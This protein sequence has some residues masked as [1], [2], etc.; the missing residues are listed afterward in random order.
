MRLLVFV[1][2]AFCAWVSPL[3]A[4]AVDAPAKTAPD[5]GAYTLFDPVPDTALRDFATDRPTKSNVPTT[6]DAGH[7]QIEM[8]LVNDTHSNAGGA[9]TRLYTAFDPVLKLGVTNHIDIEFQFNGY[10]WLE[11]A[12]PG[13]RTLRESGAGDLL[14]RTKVNLFGNEGGPALALIPYVKLATA[15]SAI[16]NGQTEGGLIATFTQPL[17]L[18]FTL[19]IMPEIDVLKNIADTGR[20]ANFAQLINISH[21]LGPNLTIYGEL[22]SALGTDARNP[23]IYTIDTALAWAVTDTM[24][25]DIGANVGLNRAAP[26]LQLYTGIAR[27]F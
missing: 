14:L 18:D 16:G 4:Q 10:T 25:L 1:L 26:N 5:K 22:Y 19:L 9:T 13:A 12:A 23:P 21:P 2:T 27:R 17:P 8:D 6:V 15:A 11:T 20:H 7:V 24:Q 3:L